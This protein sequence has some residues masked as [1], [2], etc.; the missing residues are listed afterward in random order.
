M[1]D[2]PLDYWE[3]VRRVLVSLA[4]LLLAM[5]LVQALT[6]LVAA[7]TSAAGDPLGIAR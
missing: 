3:W 2:Q 5:P 6:A 7:W 4:W 1:S